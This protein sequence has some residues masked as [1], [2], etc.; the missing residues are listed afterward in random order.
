MHGKPPVRV[1]LAA[2]FLRVLLLAARFLRGV[3]EESDHLAQLRVVAE[4]VEVRVRAGQVQG[5]GQLPLCIPFVNRPRKAF[6]EETHDVGRLC[7]DGLARAVEN[8]DPFVPVRAGEV[9]REAPPCSSSARA[10]TLA[11][12]RP[13]TR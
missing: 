3:D 10:P 13:S 4:R 8:V 6:D 11:T 7:G 2:R 9:D 12:V 5:Q 1:R